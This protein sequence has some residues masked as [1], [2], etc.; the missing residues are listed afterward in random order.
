MGRSGDTMVCG[1][2]IDLHTGVGPYRSGRS[3]IPHGRCAGCRWTSSSRVDDG[4]DASAIHPTGSVWGC[5]TAGSDTMSCGLASDLHTGA[6][7]HRSGRI[8][9][10]MRCVG[11]TDRGLDRAVLSAIGTLRRYQPSGQ[12]A[13][14][15]IGTL[16]RYHGA[17]LHRRAYR[18]RSGHFC[19]T[20]RWCVLLVQRAH[21]GWDAVATPTVGAGGGLSGNCEDFRVCSTSHPRSSLPLPSS[22]YGGIDSS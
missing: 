17:C 11:E 16:R 4:R 7:R 20:V 13:A 2:V 21:V 19:D 1:L 5:C 14:V 18:R 3:A 22:G 6:G 8:C 10:T 12:C 15:D 9:D